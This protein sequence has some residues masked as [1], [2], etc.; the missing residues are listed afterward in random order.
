MGWSAVINYAILIAWFAIF[1]LGRG[2]LGRVHG[3]MFGIPTE[4]ANQMM[5]LLIGIYKLAILMFNLVPYIA[6]VLISR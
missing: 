3:R 6:L 1:Y 4:K 5:Y 2:W